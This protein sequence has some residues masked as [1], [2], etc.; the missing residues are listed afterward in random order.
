MLFDDHDPAAAE[1]QRP[2]V[3]RKARRSLA[4]QAKAG[5]KRTTDDLPVHSFRTLLSDPGPLT[6]NTM[7]VADGD[8]TFTMLTQPTPAQQRCFD[9]LGVTPQ[10]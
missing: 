9:L 1:R 10:M 6:A 8:A 7:R 4:A 3:V 5:S 2:A